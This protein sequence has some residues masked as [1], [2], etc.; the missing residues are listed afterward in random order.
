M[1]YLNQKVKVVTER[2][3][4]VELFDSLEAARAK[5]PTLDPEINGRDFTWG[6]IDG[7]YMRFEDWSTEHIMSI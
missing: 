1:I 2:A 4:K 5:Y 7:E 3:T 6:M